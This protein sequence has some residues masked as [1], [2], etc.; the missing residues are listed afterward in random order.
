MLGAQTW[1]SQS[2]ATQE[3]DCCRGRLD[4]VTDDFACN[5][6]TGMHTRAHTQTQ[7]TERMTVNEYESSSAIHYK[8]RKIVAFLKCEL[9]SHTVVCSLHSSMRSN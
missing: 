5:K 7:H 2:R 6:N 3:A 9:F 1:W 8:P 4:F